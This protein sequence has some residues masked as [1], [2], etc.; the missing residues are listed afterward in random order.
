M[1]AA[2]ADDNGDQLSEA[3]R[4]VDRISS[5]LRNSVQSV[6]SANNEKH[7]AQRTT[8]LVGAIAILRLLK[9]RAMSFCTEEADVAHD[10]DDYGIT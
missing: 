7:D 5:M 8:I 6:E 4:R 1:E 2:N 3:A 9:S 10:D